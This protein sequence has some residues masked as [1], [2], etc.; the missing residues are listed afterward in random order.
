MARRLRFVPERT[1]VEVTCR[2]VQCRFLLKPFPGWSE[3]FA[4]ALARAQSLYPVEVHAFVC[5]SNHFHLLVS[6]ADA[7]Q[8]AD[9]MR[10]LLCKLSIEA[11]RRHGWSG[12]LFQRRYQAILVSSEEA[13]QVG[14]LRYL[15]A[16]GVKENLVAKT[17]HWPG[18]HCGAALANGGSVAGI[19]RDRTREWVARQRGRR[20]EPDEALQ[21]LALRL[22]VLP[23]W[24]G[25]SDEL[26]QSHVREL[27]AQIELEAARQRD[28]HGNSCLG[29]RAVLA[30]DPHEAPFRSN[31]S[32]APFCHAVVRRVRRELWRAYGV[33]L[34]AYRD[35]A[36]RLASGD[37]GVC[38]PEG[39]F[40][41]AIPFAGA[42][43]GGDARVASG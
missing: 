24:R 10:H 20:L 2:T 5:L 21:H 29:R 25:R 39:S 43:V 42:A 11:A 16:H 1:L 7:R 14:R 37:R 12:P 26:L 18:P 9:F 28:L 3:I 31:R 32:P 30:Q 17:A 23:C 22:A 36:K 33:F 27:I 4:G 15:L 35:A 6:P 34:A 41:P 19:W 40:P 13:A 8:L 38:F